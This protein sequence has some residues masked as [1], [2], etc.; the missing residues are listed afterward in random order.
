MFDFK[1]SKN[2]F[3]HI[4]YHKCAST[5][6]QNNFFSKIENF[7]YIF[8]SGYKREY[9]NYVQSMKFEPN[10]LYKY[11]NSLIADKLTNENVKDVKLIIS[12][13]E[14]S[15]HP[16]GKKSIDYKIIL[17]NLKKAFPNAKIIIV[18]RNQIDYLSSIYSFRVTSKGQ[19]YRSLRK[20][21]YE[22]GKEGLFEKMNYYNLIKDYVDNFGKEN[23]LVIP[24]EILRN[25]PEQFIRKL[26]SFM[27]IEYSDSYVC[28]N[29]INE[30]SKCIYVI[31]FW[32][33]INYFF[34]VFLNCLEELGIDFNEEYKYLKIR[35]GYYY[36]KRK[37][38]P[39]QNKIFRNSKKINVSKFLTK[40][41]IKK[42]KESNNKLIYLCNL[43]LANFNYI[44]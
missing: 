4:G 33:L 39:L 24:L 34:S 26:C 18:I 16:E 22:L 12:H 41:Q 25:S 44:I 40:K 9:L 11:L 35:Y 2:I 43:D 1:N 32:R 10:K 5:Y 21:L 29:K 6:L 42:V 19:E 37:L 3:I 28:K 13:E 8:L 36:L 14:L 7:Y 30:S 38:I 17:R 31:N 15:G 27:R 20:F 23:V